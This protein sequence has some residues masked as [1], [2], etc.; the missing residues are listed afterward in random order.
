MRHGYATAV[1]TDLDTTPA[2]DM[3]LLR[4]KIDPR[5]VV[6]VPYAVSQQCPHGWGCKG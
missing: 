3:E 5:P 4:N 2:A 1:S 6:D